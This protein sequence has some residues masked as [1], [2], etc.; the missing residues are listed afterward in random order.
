MT[1]G[2]GKGKKQAKKAKISV[3]DVPLD[4]K[5]ADEVCAESGLEP[6]GHKWTDEECKQLWTYVEEFQDEL[7][8]GKD[9]LTHP[10]VVAK[11][12][13]MLSTYLC[14][15]SGPPHLWPI[16]TARF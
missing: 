6:V 8:H 12:T 16:T 4:R 9:Y 3:P 5:H 10:Q 7:Y 15:I 13:T 11:I 1:K 14:K 2:K